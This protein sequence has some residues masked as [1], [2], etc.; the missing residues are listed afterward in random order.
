MKDFA[1]RKVKK[2]ATVGLFLLGRRSRMADVAVG[3]FLC[4]RV[5]LSNIP[6]IGIEGD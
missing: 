5:V 3:Q 4:P 1:G 6:A 2:Q